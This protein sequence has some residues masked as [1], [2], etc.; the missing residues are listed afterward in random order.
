MAVPLGYKPAETSKQGEKLVCKLNKSIYDLKASRQ[1]FSKFSTA[2][3][4]HGFSQ[5]KSD[6]SLFTRG[7]GKSFVALLVYVD[8]IIIIRPSPDEIDVVKKVLRSH[9]MLKDLGAVNTSLV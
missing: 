2:L 5:S 4:S 7:H 6:Y 8:D 9:F 3:L 1:W